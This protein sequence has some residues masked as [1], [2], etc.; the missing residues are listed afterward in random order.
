M[1]PLRSA[2]IRLCPLSPPSSM[3]EEEENV[4]LS[5]NDYRLPLGKPTLVFFPP[6]ARTGP[7]KAKAAKRKL[8]EPVVVQVMMDTVSRSPTREEVAAY[9]DSDTQEEITAVV[10]TILFD[11]V[12]NPHGYTPAKGFEIEGNGY[13]LRGF[14]EDWKWGRRLLLEWGGTRV[15]PCADKWTFRFKWT[16]NGASKGLA[17]SEVVM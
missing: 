10:E 4:Q 15:N 16:G 3:K 12:L 17:E 2:S 9:Y 13:I 5:T 6:Q 14:K 8:E 1:P 11:N 7:T